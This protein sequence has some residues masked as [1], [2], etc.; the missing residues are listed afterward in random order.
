VNWMLSIA[1]S[2]QFSAMYDHSCFPNGDRKN[3]WK[4]SS[5]LTPHNGHWSVTSNVLLHLFLHV[6]RVRGEPPCKMLHLWRNVA[7]PNTVP[8]ISLLP[9]GTKMVDWVNGCHISSIASLYALWTVN[10]PCFLG[11]QA[12]W[13][14]SNLGERV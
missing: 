6:G 9:S 8:Y 1:E 2:C 13:S 11:A 3:G 10:S 5:V 4:L 12:R 7:F 14:A